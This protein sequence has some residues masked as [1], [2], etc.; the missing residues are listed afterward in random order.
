MVTLNIILSLQY[1]SM[2]GIEISFFFSL[3]VIFQPT[4]AVVFEK[5]NIVIYAINVKY[6]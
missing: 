5:V 1:A 3:H 6:F 2:N 4:I